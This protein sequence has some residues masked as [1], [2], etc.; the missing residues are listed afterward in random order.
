[1][2]GAFVPALLNRT[3]SRPKVSRVLANSARTESGLVTSVGTLSI[4][5][6]V[7]D[8]DAAVRSNGSARRPASTTE[9]PADCSATETALPAPVTR[10][11]L[12]LS[13]I[14]LPSPRQSAPRPTAKNPKRGDALGASLHIVARAPFTAVPFRSS[15]SSKVSS[16]LRLRKL[17]L[18]RQGRTKEDL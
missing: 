10:A 17:L 18:S 12:P 16:G 1:M 6:P 7:A 14:N 9:Y 2:A 15:R 13:V 5:P 3:S 8:A 11:I 4:L